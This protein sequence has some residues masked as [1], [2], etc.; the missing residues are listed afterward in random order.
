MAQHATINLFMVMRRPSTSLTGTERFFT[1]DE[2]IVSKTDLQ[3]RITYANDLFLEI[4]GYTESDVLGAPHSLIR[5][6]DMPRCIFK[7]MWDKL[8]DGQEIF[9]FVVNR[10]QN[11]DHYWV[12]AHVTP[13][14]DERGQKVGYHSNRRVPTRSAVEQVSSIYASLCKEENRHERNVDGMSAS[15]VLFQ[16]Q[17][18]ERDMTYDEYVWSLIPR[19]GAA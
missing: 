17:L 15:S 13:T 3:G 11:G 14:F 16:K 9:A 5:H 4:A 1:A 12:F 7:L 19:M 6:P 2:I 10:C 18:A 8:N